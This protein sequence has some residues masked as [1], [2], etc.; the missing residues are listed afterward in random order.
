[1][2]QDTKTRLTREDWILA[3]FRALSRSGPSALKAEPLA[4]ELKATKGSFYW[5]FKD[6]ADFE[7]A[8]L[9]YWRVQATEEVIASV[10]RKGGAPEEDLRSLLKIVT[11]LRS[12]AHGGLRAESAIRQWAA[13][14]SRVAEAR[15]AVDVARLD[16]LESLFVRAGF[17]QERAKLFSQ[18]MYAA[19]IGL[20]Y[21]ELQQLGSAREG[22]SG[23][24]E[25]LLSAEKS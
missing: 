9:V 4:R 17:V 7:S 24:S 5:H 3:G 22:L 20:E 11:G 2:T 23:L 18:A 16:Y 10:A 14:N 12:E 8:M 25:I 21:L 1:M 19:L 6:V 13:T 15:H